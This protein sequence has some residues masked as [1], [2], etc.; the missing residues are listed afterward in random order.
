[1]GDYFIEFWG[2]RGE[3]DYDKK[4]E[5]KTEL[6]KQYSIPLISLNQQDLPILD[7]RLEKLIE[8]YGGQKWPTY[9]TKIQ[10]CE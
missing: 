8:E 3:E 10:N 2:L 9:D 1:V 7:F 4:M 5:V 6:A